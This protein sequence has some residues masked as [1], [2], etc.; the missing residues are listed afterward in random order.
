MAFIKWDGSYSVGVAEIDAQHQKLVAMLNDLHDAMRQGKG[1][2][3]LGK[4]LSGMA[5]YTVTHFATEEKYFEKFGYPD[6]KTHNQEHADF[7][8]RVSEFKSEFEKGDIS[9]TIPVMTFLKDW[10]MNHIKGS[11]KQY[12]PF[13]N[14]KGIK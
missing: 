5:D 6:A 10:L 13:L 9:L 3:A 4:I 11:D 2:D 1:K 14:A 7:V 8:K 12:G